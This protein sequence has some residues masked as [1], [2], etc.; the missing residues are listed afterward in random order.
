MLKEYKTIRELVGPLMLVDHVENVKYDELVRI[1]QE[2]GEE[3]IGKVLEINEDELH[4]KGFA[5]ANGL[6]N[7]EEITNM[8][9]GL[10]YKE[11]LNRATK[12]LQN[13]LLALGDNAEFRTVKIN[14]KDYIVDKKHIITEAY[15][16]IMPMIYRTQFGLESQDDV[17]N[18]SR[19][20]NFFFRRAL[21]NF[22]SKVSDNLFDIELDD[23]SKEENLYDSIDAKSIIEI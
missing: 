12:N 11:V 4:F 2:N 13:D 16:L 21:N 14:K 22:K 5:L 23:F 17:Y 3:R 1:R 15:E 10:L 18:I 20:P 8:D 19:D 9:A 6:A 7:S